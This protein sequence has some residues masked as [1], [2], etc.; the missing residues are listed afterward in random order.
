MM[1]P[2]TSAGL[3]PRGIYEV[4]W[5]EVLEQLGRSDQRKRLLVGLLTGLQALKQAGCEVAYI[6]GSFVT[7]KL[8]PGD[9]DVCYKSDTINFSLLDPVLKDFSNRRAAQKQKYGGEFFEAEAEAVPDGTLYLD[10]FQ[11]TKDGKR[12]GI[13]LLKLNE[14]PEEAS[15]D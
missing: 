7:A 14:L 2:F 1:P 12:K 3:L 10:F 4:S 5:S 9:V 8:E 13:I 6:D 15:H 11:M